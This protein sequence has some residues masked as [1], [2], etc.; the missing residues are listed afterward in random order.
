MKWFVNEWYLIN[1]KEA[2]R[3]GLPTRGA[4]PMRGAGKEPLNLT[5]EV[6]SFHTCNSFLSLHLEIVMLSD[7]IKKKYKRDCGHGIRL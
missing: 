4:G 5:F 2:L 1:A 6:W 3:V 7:M